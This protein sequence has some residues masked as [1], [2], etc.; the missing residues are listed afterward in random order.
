MYG[1]LDF[2]TAGQS[3][4]KVSLLRNRTCKPGN[5]DGLVI[6]DIDDVIYL[7]AYVFTNGPAPVTSC[8]N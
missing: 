5:A 7:T 2:A 1:D 3:S 6:V 8:D 4:D